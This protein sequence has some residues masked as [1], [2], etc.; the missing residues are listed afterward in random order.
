MPAAE[1]FNPEYDRCW[2]APPRG[3]VNFISC[4]DDE[5][6]KIEITTNVIPAKAGIQKYHT[7]FL[8]A[9]KFAK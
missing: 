4:K 8:S 1:I 5:P 7:E 2:I 3:I 6:A 9:V